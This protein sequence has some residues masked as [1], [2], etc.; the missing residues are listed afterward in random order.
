MVQKSCIERHFSILEKVNSM[1]S[2]VPYLTEEVLILDKCFI[3]DMV[4]LSRVLLK[5]ALLNTALLC[6]ATLL[7]RKHGRRSSTN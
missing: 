3:M 7:M 4:S 5:S 1:F 6:Y 2:D